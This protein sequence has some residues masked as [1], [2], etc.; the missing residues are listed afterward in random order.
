MPVF[1]N[2]DS[3][4]LKDQE[5]IIQKI[6]GFINEGVQPSTASG[7]KSKKGKNNEAHVV[8]EIDEDIM[9]Q[10]K[11]IKGASERK[12]SQNKPDQGFLLLD[13][14]KA[15]DGAVQVKCNTSMF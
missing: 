3:T 5:T 9:N 4:E 13:S 11:G 12:A 1:A 15:H 2:S 6:N 14:L 8:G 7:K 10:Y